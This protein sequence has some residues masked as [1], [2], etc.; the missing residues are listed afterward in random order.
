[1]VILWAAWAMGADPSSYTG[2]WVLDLEASQSPVAL[3]AEQGF[4]W[5][6]REVAKRMNVTQVMAATAERVELRIESSLRNSSETLIVDGVPRPG[7]GRG[8]PVS[9][10]HRWAT[11]G[12]LVTEVEQPVGEGCPCK[13]V[14]N[15]SIDG[16]IL[17]Q[18]ITWTASDGRVVSLKRVLRLAKPS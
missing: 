8:G 12:A 18:W 4:S 16:D 9:A 7:E 10:L 3:M 17:T 2:T 15:R 14:V 13:T 1:M 11:D 6:E 5:V